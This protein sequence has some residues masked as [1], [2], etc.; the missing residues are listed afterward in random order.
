MGDAVSQ[1]RVVKL[2]EVCAR[3]GLHRGTVHKQVSLGRFPKPI[4]LSEAR[5]GWLESDINDWLAARIKER[6]E[7][8]A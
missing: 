6:D 8:A 2:S 4:T 3:L 7:G 1:E 5:F